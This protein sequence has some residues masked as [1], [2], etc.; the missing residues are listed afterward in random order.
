M[1]YIVEICNTK[2][3]PCLAFIS[4]FVMAGVGDEAG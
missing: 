2:C 3:F 1:L 4:P